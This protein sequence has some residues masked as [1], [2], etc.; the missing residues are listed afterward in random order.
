VDR[1]IFE[2]DLTAYAFVEV[3]EIYGPQKYGHAL[4]YLFRREG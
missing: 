2:A 4:F 3:Y 1:V